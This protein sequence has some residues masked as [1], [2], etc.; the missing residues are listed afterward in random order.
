MPAAGRLSDRLELF[1]GARSEAMCRVYARIAEADAGSDWRITGTLTGPEC[2]YGETLPATFRFAD[3]G[4]NGPPLAEALVPE[5]NLWTP[6]M[7]H[8]YRADVQIACGD[9]VVERVER[10]FGIRPLGATPRG[11]RFAGKGWALRGVRAEA[12]DDD[13]LRHWHAADTAMVVA[14]PH[15]GLCQAASRTGVLIVA[16]LIGAAIDE[17]RRLSRWPAVGLVSLPST[18]RQ[19]PPGVGR[20]LL[21][22]QKFA[23]GEAIAPA[24]GIDLVF[25]EVADHAKLPPGANDCLLP[26]VAVRPARS[27]TSVGQGLRPV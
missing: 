22:A 7:P 1:F 14:H 26:I 18:V 25:C 27:A 15:D 10:I 3:R 17:L 11:L 4:P 6:E 5:P 8:L 9:A 12:A 2:V 13:D 20:N 21:F 24:E 23:A 16:E 19:L